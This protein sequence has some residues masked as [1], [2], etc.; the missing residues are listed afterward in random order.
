MDSAAIDVA[1]LLNDQRLKEKERNRTG[2]KPII[3]TI[4]FCGEQELP[5]RGDKDSGPLTL[6]KPLGKDLNSGLCYDTE[7]AMIIS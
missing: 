2:L 7:Q 3:A 4:I 1:S 5:L 6:E